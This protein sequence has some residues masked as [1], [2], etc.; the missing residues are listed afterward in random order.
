MVKARPRLSPLTVSKVA[1]FP[2]CPHPQ[3]CP[4][5]LAARPWLDLVNRRLG[6]WL[7]MTMSSRR[8]KQLTQ[9]APGA[10][11]T[12]PMSSDWRNASHG[13]MGGSILLLRAAAGRSAVEPARAARRRSRLAPATKWCW[14][15]TTTA[16][17]SSQRPR[18][19]GL[20]Q[21]LLLMSAPATGISIQP[22]QLEDALAPEDAGHHRL[23]SARRPGADM[24]AV[25]EIARNRGVG[26]IEDARSG[27]GA[28]N[29][30]LQA[31][32]AGTWGDLGILSFGGRFEATNCG[33]RRR[34]SR[35]AADLH[36]RFLRVLA[37]RGNFWFILYRN[38]QAADPAPPVG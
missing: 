9:M 14:Q 7:P 28:R 4:L 20:S 11:I 19:L 12:G 37:H 36:Q 10:S 18:P 1:R 2:R 32:M 3:T 25:M 34:S 17:N 27:A 22:V 29:Q 21:S 15:P 6:L 26:V 30:G 16:A 23:A 8:C 13:I 24:H 5:C 38:S 33:T 31:R 35:T